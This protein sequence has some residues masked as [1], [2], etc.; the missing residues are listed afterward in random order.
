MIYH[1]MRKIVIETVT[2]RVNHWINEKGRFSSLR[3]RF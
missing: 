3:G 1:D 2:I